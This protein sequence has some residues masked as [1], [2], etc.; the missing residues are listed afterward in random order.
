MGDHLPSS[1]DG[2]SGDADAAALPAL[3]TERDAHSNAVA[4]R[5]ARIECETTTDAATERD[6]VHVIAGLPVQ[7]ISSR[8]RHKQVAS[9]A[10]E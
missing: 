1:L 6:D 9:A 4:A 2:R 7:A 8:G 5:R 3:A 10:A